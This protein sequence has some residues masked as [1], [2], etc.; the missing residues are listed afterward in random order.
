MDLSEPGVDWSEEETVGVPE[1]EDPTEEKHDP[2]EVPFEPWHAELDLR[3]NT[4][5]KPIA[6]LKVVG[7]DR[8][9]SSP[10]DW[11]TPAPETNVLD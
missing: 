2:D 11:M 1:E 10:S 5:I 4:W 8:V 3:E 9:W 7:F 6:K